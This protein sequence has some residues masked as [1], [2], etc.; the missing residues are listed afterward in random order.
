MSIRSLSSLVFSLVVSCAVLP[1][2][3]AS[4]K[5]QQT[6]VTF[7][8]PVE[9]P[10]SVLPAGSYWFVRDI[11]NVNIVRIFSLDWKT[12]FAT[13][14]TIETQRA[15]PSGRTTF[16]FAERKSAEPEALLKWFASHQ[17]VGHEFLYSKQEERELAQDGQH[18]VLTAPSETR[19]HAGF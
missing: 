1:F 19:P 5:D 4:E 10:G 12:L 11:D 9:I 6:R 3:Q 7:D 14:Q 13:E 17:T 15:E 18:E 16:V 8:Q 2:A